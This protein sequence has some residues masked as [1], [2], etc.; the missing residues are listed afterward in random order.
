MHDIAFHYGIL[1]VDYSDKLKFRVMK[2]YAVY[3]ETRN[4][5]LC[6]GFYREDAEAYCK[7]LYKNGDP[8]WQEMRKAL[9]DA[10][11]YDENFVRERDYYE[12]RK[13]RAAQL[14]ELRKQE[15]EKQARRC[16]LE[17]KADRFERDVDIMRG[18]SGHTME[19]LRIGG[20]VSD[21]DAQRYKDLRDSVLDDL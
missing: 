6:L 5:K 2:E 18:G 9:D 1:G 16:E 3:E 14:A 10:K 4:Y 12:A 13:E 11:K 21:V 15:E 8:R 19:E 17:K 20:K 7:E